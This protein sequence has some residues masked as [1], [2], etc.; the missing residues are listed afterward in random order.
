MRSCLC[1]I[2]VCQVDLSDN[3]LC[4]VDEDGDGSYDPS[5]IQALA[6]ALS[7]GKAVLK[8]IVLSLNPIKDEGAIAIGE[9]LKT[10]K[11]LETLELAQC[12]IGQAGGKAIGVGLQAGIAVLK[13][14]DVSANHMN[15]EA[16]AALQEA[17]KGK[18]GFEL[19]V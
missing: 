14:C 12:R 7:S 15:F 3:M 19:L 13:R 16:K 2:H 18:K 4:G 10:N 1:Q 8:K 9:S 6:A 17:V 11:T 5:G